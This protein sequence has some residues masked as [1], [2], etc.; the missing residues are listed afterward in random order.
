MFYERKE[1]ELMDVEFYSTFTEE[2]NRYKQKETSFFKKI[3][4]ILFIIILIIILLIWGSVQLYK[5]P[6]SSISNVASSPVQ[7]A[8]VV[9]PI[10]VIGTKKEVLNIDKEHV[11]TKKLIKVTPLESKNREV[12]NLME[13]ILKELAL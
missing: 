5:V 7:P 6:S 3:F 8:Q 10:E 12:E 11:Q 2:L 9:A 4:I 1:K 13:D